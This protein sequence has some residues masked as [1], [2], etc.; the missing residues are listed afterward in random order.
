MDNKNANELIMLGT[1]NAIVTKCYN[2][3]FVL[4]SGTTRLLVDAGGGNGVLAQLEKVGVSVDELSA[5]YLRR[6]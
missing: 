4:R 3:C 6:P 2:T 1:G 5:M